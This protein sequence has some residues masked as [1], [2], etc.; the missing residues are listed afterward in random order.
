MVPSTKGETR[1]TVLYTTYTSMVSRAGGLPMILTPGSPDEARATIGRLDGLLLSG[2]GDVDPLRYDGSP[3]ETL[4]GVDPMRD[5][6]EI[7]LARAA[8]DSGLPTLAI[9]RGM[10]VLNVALGGSLIEDI[11]TEQPSA[12]QHRVEGLGTV[13]P[14]HGV[15]LDPGSAVATALGTTEPQVNTVHH[16]AIRDLGEG[17][18]TVGTAPDG[19]IEAIEST[20]GW[21]LWCVQWHPEY[22]GP[23]DPPSLALFQTLVQAATR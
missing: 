19:I 6:F 3:V 22:L 11:P 9:C 10:Q 23:D 1:A 13:E 7:A 12:L 4:Y 15:S 8:R 2:G 14:Q 18:R 5:E 20:D 16:Q 21:P 17:L